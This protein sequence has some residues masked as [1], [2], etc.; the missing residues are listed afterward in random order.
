MATTSRS[1]RR[2]IGALSKQTGC[3][4]ETIRYYERIGLMPPATRSEGGHRLYGELE[5][6]RLGFIRRTRQLGFALDDVRTLLKLVDGGRYTC[7]Q[8]KRITV[9]HLDAVQRKVA[10]L[11]KIER[12][13]REMAA[14]CDGGTVPQC[15]VI[16][17]L[18]DQTSDRA[19]A[20][21][22]SSRRTWTPRRVSVTAASTRTGAIRTSTAS[23]GARR[24]AQDTGDE[25]LPMASS[26][27][28]GRRSCSS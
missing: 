16:D 15:P 23:S 5:A 21:V 12:V 17:A 11:R 6:R 3:N 8:V 13:L 18:F 26:T 1:A 24:R 22:A 19:A 10:D 4:I 7:A 9:H 14:Q 2:G 20:P 27:S 25:S 28:G